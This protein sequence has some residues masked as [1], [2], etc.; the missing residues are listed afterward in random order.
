MIV[1]N[2]GRDSLGDIIFYYCKDGNNYIFDGQVDDKEK[3]ISVYAVGYNGK[4][5]NKFIIN[6]ESVDL[7]KN[8]YHLIIRKNE[9]K[10]KIKNNQIVLI[11]GLPY[12]TTYNKS[13]SN[14]WGEVE[15]LDKFDN[16]NNN[17]EFD[18]PKP[19][20]VVERIITICSNPN[21]VVADFFVGSGTTAFACKKLN[22]RGIFC[23][24][25]EKS[26]EHLTKLLEEIK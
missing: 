21:D 7:N 4:E 9:L 14:I 15:M 16:T 17:A 1:Q 8:S 19:S 5:Y 12:M 11:N 22:R 25:N 18:T 10:E 13:I 24:I 2:A 23:D 6:N 26:C 20:A 3:I